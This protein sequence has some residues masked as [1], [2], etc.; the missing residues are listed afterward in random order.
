[1]LES[2]GGQ[3]HEVGDLN[4]IHSKLISFAEFNDDQQ[5]ASLVPDAVAGNVDLKSV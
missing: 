5:I 4:Q 1:M 3:F 2:V